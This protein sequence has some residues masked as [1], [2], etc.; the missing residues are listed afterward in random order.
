MAESVPTSPEQTGLASTWTVV[1]GC[2]I[3]ALTWLLIAFERVPFMPIGRTA[4]ALLGACLMV[5]TGVLSS[6]EVCN[7]GRCTFRLQVL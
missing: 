5:A 4:G 6:E 3:F 1:A 7:W 2:T